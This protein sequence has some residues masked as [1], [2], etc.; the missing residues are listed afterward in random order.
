MSA[1]SPTPPVDA[2]LQTYR[3]DRE[4]GATR[5]LREYLEM[6]PGAETAIAREYVALDGKIADDIVQAPTVIDDGLDRLGPY[7]ILHELGRGGQGVVY[8]AE[9]TRLG[10]QVALKVLKALGPEYVKLALRFKREAAIASRLDDPGICTVFDAGVENGTP[11]IA[12][13]YL[14]GESLAQRISAAAGAGE[15]T[16]CI[17]LSNANSKDPHTDPDDV[18]SAGHP[19]SIADTLQV[20]ALFEQVARSLDIAHRAGVIHRDI[21]PGN[22]MVTPQGTGIIM[23]FGLARADDNDHPTLTQSG[24]LFG[25]PAY[26]SPEQLTRHSIRLDA[27][28]DIWSLGVTLYECLVGQ[29]PFTAPTREGLYRK[30]I[31]TDPDD[32][33]SLNPDVSRDLAVL[34]LTALEKDRDR[35]Y[36]TAAA[37]ADD[38]GRVLRGEPITARP[39]SRTR[40]LVRSMRRH[41]VAATVLIAAALTVPAITGLAGYVAAN[42]DDIEA[43]RS[44]RERALLE[45]TLEAAYLE[46]DEGRP[47][48]SARLFRKATERAP[49]SVEAI[50]GSVL[51]ALKTGDR[52]SAVGQVAKVAALLD[53]PPA[54]RIL[55]ASLEAA[56]GEALLRTSAVPLTG[57]GWFVAGSTWLS[58]SHD[59]GTHSPLGAQLATRARYALLHA[60][61][62]TSPARRTYHFQ[63]AHAMWHAPAEGIDPRQHRAISRALR[64]RWPDSGE[65]SKW[66]ALALLPVAPNEALAL[67]RT[68]A[69]K[70]PDHWRAQEGLAQVAV[71]TKS[72]ADAE[73]GARRMLTLLAREQLNQGFAYNTLTS[74]LFQLGR[75]EEAEIAG[76]RGV[77]RFPRDPEAYLRIVDVY[78]ATG[79]PKKAAAA[80]KMAMSVVSRSPERLMW[81]GDWLS[82][83]KQFKQ[84][85]ALYEEAAGLVS[86]PDP[87]IQV[88]RGTVLAKLGRFA[89][90]RAR[91]REVLRLDPGSVSAARGIVITWYLEGRRKEFLE[92]APAF[93]RK[94][95]QEQGVWDCLLLTRWTMREYALVET[96]ARECLRDN[97]DWHSALVHLAK[98]LQHLHRDDE[99]EQVLRRCI[100][101]R[102]ET[103]EAHYD[104]ASLLGRTQRLPEAEMRYR[105]AMKLAPTFAEAH[106]N[107]GQLLVSQG[108]LAEAVGHL[109]KGHALGEA[110]GTEWK[111]SSSLW[112]E[113][114]ERLLAIKLRF[115]GRLAELDASG[116]SLLADEIRSLSAACDRTHSATDAV[117]LWTLAFSR[118]HGQLGR[119]FPKAAGAAATAAARALKDEEA[120]TYRDRAMSWL[121]D[122]LAA[123]RRDARESGRS[124]ARIARIL[125]QVL[126]EPALATVRDAQQLQA[127]A[128]TE[129][130]AWTQAWTA[131]RDA[132]EEYE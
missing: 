131:V 20:V 60:V 91:H 56:D 34:I 61:L 38:L 80:V 74:S 3:I 47:E 27:R 13:R 96:E 99:S 5:P 35:R 67:A 76:L 97:P 106:C 102:P 11:F 108:R 72:W 17:A 130:V 69:E 55:R 68:A 117:L 29:R 62:A 53:D 123:L 110:R 54:V 86:A 70:F 129:R 114:A 26:M 6:F 59:E 44:L 132:L 98:A 16:T 12:M 28:S 48:E 30:I 50:A 124:D 39:I 19:T 25:T 107:L 111:Y 14:E 36:Q 89:E 31:S 7:R 120:R 24:D 119:W 32:P 46:L 23:D 43:Q 2:F 75:F 10:R 33:V 83:L 42:L 128:E 127:L 21:K 118:D 65:A 8:L 90:A 37:M 73:R 109:K 9:D 87:Q 49:S 92:A 78:Q 82:T 116:D 79:R 94:H 45:D 18:P 71:R 63:L 101:V 113:N 122:G 115:A 81:L 104:L 103:H 41:P 66:A 52:P 125:K 77:R 126:K 1:P 100:A 121:V 58:R 51:A 15:A 57:A 84:A 95:P 112:V 85:L 64:T 105:E 4:A 88:R 22:V 93:L 40:R